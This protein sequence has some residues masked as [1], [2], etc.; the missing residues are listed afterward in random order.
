MGVKVQ[1]VFSEN[2]SKPMVKYYGGHPAK[3]FIRV[4]PIQFGY[5]DWILCSSNG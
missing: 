5:K 4:K 1:I 3:Q 2:P